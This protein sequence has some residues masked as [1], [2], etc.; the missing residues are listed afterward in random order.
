[1][2]IKLR[3][4]L[5]LLPL[6]ALLSSTFS[7]ASSLQSVPLTTKPLDLSR[8]PTTEELMAAGQLGGQLY[9]T[10]D[11]PL[12]AEELPKTQK[13]TQAAAE[14]QLAKNQAVNLSFG[15]AIQL[16]NQHE[17]KRAVILFKEHVQQYP[18]SPWAAE[19]A[20]HVGCDAIYN[21]RYQEA[22]EQLNWI[23]GRF[24]KSSHAGAKQLVAKAKLRLANLKVLQNNFPEAAKHY[25]TLVKEGPDWR[26]RTYGSHWIQQLSRMKKDK[27]AL[28]NCGFQALAALLEH[29]GRR[30]E[31][32][33]VRKMQPASLQGQ[34]L[35]ELREIAAQYGYPLNGR[36]VLPEELDLLPLPA[37]LQMAAR[38]AGDGGH[39]WML[40]KI[41]GGVL[42]LFDPQS[43]HRFS[44]SREEF[45]REWGGI[46]LVF[47][48][49]AE[50]PGT[51]L[52]LVEMEESYG[53]C[54]GV[55]RPEEG[56]GESDN[57]VNPHGCGGKGSPVWSVN[58][59]NLNLFVKDIPLWYTPSYGPSVQIAL[60]Y[61]S[62]SATANHEPFG[63]K[64]QFNYG[65]YLTVDTSGN[66]LVFMPDGRRDQYAPDDAGGYTRPYKVHNT[67]TK[68]AENHFELRFPDD[69]VFVYDIPAGT[70]SQQP[71][72]VEIRDAYGQ[73][74]SFQYN[75][76]IQLTTITDAQEKSTILTYN[77][78]GLVTQATDPFGR[79]ALFE[80]DSSRN[81][82]KITDMGGYWSSLSY[83]ENV[84][85]TSIG[86][87]SGQKWQF[88]TELPSEMSNGSN[89]YPAPGE[90]MWENYRITVTNPKEG[91]EE[92]YYD[93]Y[94]GYSWMVSPRN[95]IALQSGEINNYS[96]ETPKTKYYFAYT[97]GRRGEIDSIYY[98][99]G[100]SVRYGYDS[101]T[102]ERTSVSDG[103]GST[104]QYTYNDMGLVTSITDAK[105]EVTNLTYA[106]NNVDLT[107]ITNGLGTVKMTWNSQHD[108]LSVT[109][110]LN[111]TTAFTYNDKGQRTSVTEAQGTSL[112]T[113]VDYAYDPATFKLTQVAKSGNVLAS[114]TYDTIG[115]TTTATDAAGLTLTYDYNDLNHITKITYPDGKFSSATYKNCC[116]GLLASKTDRAD[117]TTK[118][119]YDELKR[120]IKTEH[121][122]GT[123]TRAEYDANGNMVKL[124]DSNS[125]ATQFVYDLNNRLSKKI[126]ADGK[127]EQFVYN[128]IGLLER[129]TNSRGF[130]IS[131]AYDA[132]HNLLAVDYS[133]DTP[134][135][136]YQYDAYDRLIQV[137]DGTGTTSYTYDANSRPLTVD[138]PWP[139]DLLAYQHD[140]LGRRTK[141]TPQAGTEISFTQDGLD[142]LTGIQAGARTYAYAY[143]GANPLVQTLT[144]PDG[145]TTAYQ[146]DSLLRLTSIANKNA[147][148]AVLTQHD[149]TYN[150]QDLRGSEA[151]TRSITAPSLAAQ[152]VTYD[153]NALN[154][155]K[156]IFAPAQAFVYDDD[157]NMTQGFT[158]EGYQITAAYDA[159]NRLKST[160]FTDSASVKHRT[161]YQ[162]GADS[163]L[164]KKL[165][166]VNGTLAA[167]S[168]YL[169]DGFNV[170]QERDGADSIV[171]EYA[172]GLN[173]GGGIGGLLDLRQGGQSYSYLYDGKGNVDGLT[174]SSGTLAAGYAYDAFGNLLTKTGTLEQP[175]R[176]STKAFDDQTGLAYYGYRFYS[177]GMGRW[178]NR[179]PIGEAGGGNLY[180]FVGNDPVNWIDPYG[181]FGLL[182]A[183]LG[184]GVDLALQLASNGGR[185][186]CV[187]W[188]QVAISAGL[189]AIGGGLTNGLI[190]GAFRFKN[191][192][193]NTWSATK[194]WGRAKNIKALQVKI[195]QQ[196]HHWLFQQNQGWGKNISNKIRNQPWNINPVSAEFNNWM[197][198]GNTNLRSLLGA[199]P[200]ARGVA[201]GSALSGIGAVV[202]TLDGGNDCECQ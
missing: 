146:Y 90:A 50:L 119:Y 102:G 157:G 134:D 151:I 164:R 175:F 160:E 158:P 47:G 66:V 185:I 17:Y 87:S 108:L 181:E 39:Y 72:L 168:R 69:S 183:V 136:A 182:G 85:L 14:K 65:S 38:N 180:G 186:E 30:A 194:H 52:S 24:A 70:A 165:V 132:N 34:S 53:A 142:R 35:E 11:L 8:T 25:S 49:G 137:Q 178:I 83:D 106:A 117:R 84:Y 138:G 103:A 51:A 44:Q 75:S 118:Y 129:Q 88:Y 145:G 16:W 144:R 18:D 127:S 55:A 199:P 188:G 125:N 170:L 148:N 200:W 169:L 190:K 159:E 191:V 63:N 113:R 133:D 33:D 74:L 79:T 97:N 26:M 201:G 23:V 100:N 114:Y 46:T 21:G 5:C 174:D 112:E 10:A 20:L 162:Y 172:W 93:G 130:E 68:I 96:I 56:T 22:D 198:K 101:T 171:R 61:N 95:Y 110:R 107:E 202:N 143:S 42:S 150:A 123:L 76:D 6:A 104:V 126:Y 98:P 195:G 32:D 2:Q 58:I 166:Y 131:Y 161:E 81:L 86:N 62:Q 173:M 89:P 19:S 91:K 27:L 196:R 41:D 105:G 12:T 29:E 82:V 135:V 28:V 184:G 99:E 111:V 154:Q 149:F 3:A 176:F 179:D 197:S 141:V 177:P 187:K 71:F 80:Y 31:A 153:H 124:I 60:S 167:E 54:C 139:N 109:D 7:A 193:S 45:S 192:G 43:G 94:H 73:K 9:P 140:A 156:N 128:S 48:G 155:L 92:Y 67:L 122:D 4:I 36:R 115:R 57:N 37:V 78:D 163:L 116:P 40:E 15:K 59:V 64:W 77:A 121:P 147:A 1:M 13:I 152:H 120:L 189:G